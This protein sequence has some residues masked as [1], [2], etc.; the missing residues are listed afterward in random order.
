M[1][2]RQRTIRA[3]FKRDIAVCSHGPCN[4]QRL[5]SRRLLPS[6]FGQFAPLARKL[7]E[8]FLFL[9]VRESFGLPFGARFPRHLGTSRRSERLRRHRRNR[10]PVALFLRARS[11]VSISSRANG[12]LGEHRRHGTDGMRLDIEALG[13]RSTTQ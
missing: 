12:A 9:S 8:I 7:F 1:V 5:A 4:K 3:A 11:A 13:C 6:A 10:V 2:R